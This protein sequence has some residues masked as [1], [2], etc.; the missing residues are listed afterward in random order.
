MAVIA[1]RPPPSQATKNRHRRGPGRKK[2]QPL[3][4]DRA[5]PFFTVLPVPVQGRPSGLSPRGILYGSP[6]ALEVFA[7]ALHGV[8]ARQG[9]H[10]CENKN[11]C[12]SDLTFHLSLL[13][14]LGVRSRSALTLTSPNP[15]YMPIRAVMSTTELWCGRVTNLA[16][17]PAFEGRPSGYSH[18]SGP[19]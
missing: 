14:A 10:A 12:S 13:P 5:C 2:G 17:E 6:A 1:R 4:Q 11:Y 15:D 18:G 8:A 3:A 16:G 19:W 7:D 9:P